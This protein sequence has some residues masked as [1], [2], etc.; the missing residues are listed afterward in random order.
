MFPKI[1]GPFGDDHNRDYSMLGRYWGPV[2]GFRGLG[3]TILF[4]KFGV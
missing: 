2:L 4:S 1:R 3:L